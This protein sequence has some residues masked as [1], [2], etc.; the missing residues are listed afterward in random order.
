MQNSTVFIVCL[1]IDSQKISTAEEISMDISAVS[2]E[3]RIAGIAYSGWII[4]FQFLLARPCLSG[5]L[6][7][8]FV[9]QVLRLSSRFDYTLVWF[10]FQ[11]FTDSIVVQ[12]TLYNVHASLLSDI[13]GTNKLIE[14]RTTSHGPFF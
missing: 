12:C 2:E 11:T 3:E 10:R 5:A 9:Q 14:Y 8:I 6:P 7:G 1:H 4:S 13:C